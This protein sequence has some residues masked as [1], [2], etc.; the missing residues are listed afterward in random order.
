[1]YYV[2]VT[3]LG[4]KTCTQEN[5]FPET[6]LVSAMEWPAMIPSTKNKRKKDHSYEKQ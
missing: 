1:M 5:T 2:K 3:L 4:C 6:F